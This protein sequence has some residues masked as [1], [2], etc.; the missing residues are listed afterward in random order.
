MVAIISLLTESRELTILSAPKDPDAEANIK[1][2]LKSAKR[3]PSSVVTFMDSENKTFLILDGCDINVNSRTAVCAVLA[4]MCAYYVLTMEHPKVYSQALGI[5][6]TFMVRDTPYNGVK[7]KGY[8]RL[9]TKLHN[10]MQVGGNRG[11]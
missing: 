2:H 3:V 11:P 5:V 7:S 8:L 9:A 1:Q 6:Q 10:K 4:L